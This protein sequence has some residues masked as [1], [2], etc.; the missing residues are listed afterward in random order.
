LRIGETRNA[1][2]SYGAKNAIAAQALQNTGTDIEKAA[3][4]F[5]T[6]GVNLA[7]DPME[8]HQIFE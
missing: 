8:G 7:C 2:I 3:M 4:E 5:K 1:S 6:P